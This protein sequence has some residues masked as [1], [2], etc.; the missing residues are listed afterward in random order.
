MSLGFTKS[1]ANSNLYY[2]VEGDELMIFL[3][4][5]DDLFLACEDNP[6]NECKKNISM[7]FEMK[8]LRMMH[9]FL[10]IEACQYLDD[11]FLNQGNM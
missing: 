8:N 9:Y 7:E 3:L 6:I 11:I 2:K 5:V 1:K 10:G 4:Y